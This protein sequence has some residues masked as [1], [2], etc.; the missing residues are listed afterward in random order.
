MNNS[1][2][3]A[4]VSGLL[5]VS[6]IG[7]S[8]FIGSTALTQRAPYAT[9]DVQRVETLQEALAHK[10]ETSKD[11][12]MHQA[13]AENYARLLNDPQTR[14][15]WAQ[16]TTYTQ[17]ARNGNLLLCIG[18]GLVGMALWEFFSGYSAENTKREQAPAGSLISRTLDQSPH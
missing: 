4:I 17:Q 1:F 5:G 2:K 11:M 7:T 15:N 8:M 18:A 12:E 6:A 13:Q 9:P 3:T 14:E 10:P 16:Y